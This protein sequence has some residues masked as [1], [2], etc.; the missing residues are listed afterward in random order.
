MMR[1]LCEEGSVES[2]PYLKSLARVGVATGTEV[3]RRCDAAHHRLIGLPEGAARFTFMKSSSVER[4][5]M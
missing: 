5:V 2:R 4:G 3:G 1:L